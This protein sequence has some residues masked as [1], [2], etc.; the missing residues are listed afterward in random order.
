MQLG[1]TERRDVRPS[2]TRPGREHHLVREIGRS[3]RRQPTP[4]ALSRRTAVQTPDSPSSPLRDPDGL[5]H[6]TWRGAATTSSRI[7][8]APGTNRSHRRSRWTP[9]SRTSAPPKPT[10]QGSALG[11]AITTY[12]YVSL[13]SALL[14][15]CACKACASSRIERAMAKWG[16][17]ARARVWNKLKRTGGRANRL[18]HYD[19]SYPGPRRTGPGACPT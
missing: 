16:T 13:P 19:G 10:G 7:W 17:P 3:T 14:A 4:G 18:E 1:R 11:P 15:R 5:P 8:R 9:P 12:L 2:P 6:R